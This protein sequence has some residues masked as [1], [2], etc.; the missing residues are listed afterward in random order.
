MVRKKKPEFFYIYHIKGEKIGCTKDWEGRRQ[1][2]RLDRGRCPKMKLLKKI[3]LIKGEKYAGDLERKLAVK[4]GYRTGVHYEV[5]LKNIRS[6]AKKGGLVGG[7]V[8]MAES[9]RAQVCSLGGKAC[10]RLG[11]SGLKHL[12]AE[13]RVENSKALIALGISGFKPELPVKCPH[14]RK[15]GHIAIMKA[16][17]F[18]RCKQNPRRTK[19]QAKKTLSMSVNTVVTCPHCKKKGNKPSMARWHFDNCRTKLST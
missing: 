18:D 14:C 19:E 4:Y 5:T 1:R 17:H 3:P 11:K 13:T 7:F 12:S 10:A 9:K 16:W 2:Y 8:T 6:S 15:S